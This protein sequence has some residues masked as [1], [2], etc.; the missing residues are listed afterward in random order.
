M[1]LPKVPIEKINKMPLAYALMIVG[2][3]LGIVA[4]KYFDK[5]TEVIAAYK[6]ENANLKA[7]NKV[8]KLEGQA[9]T[10]FWQDKYVGSLEKAQELQRKQDSTNSAILH[11]PNQDLLKALR[12]KKR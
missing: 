10:K 7:E 9:N 4:T 2:G 11:K 3:L 8:L 5:N 1:Q 12:N 6:E